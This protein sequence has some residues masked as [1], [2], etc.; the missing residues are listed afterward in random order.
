MDTK[1]NKLKDILGIIERTGVKTRVKEWYAT[2]IPIGAKI[3]E[4][5]EIN[6]IVKVKQGNNL[7]LILR[8]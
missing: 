2:M 6:N 5:S 4:I 8:G 7:H 3:F 1:Y